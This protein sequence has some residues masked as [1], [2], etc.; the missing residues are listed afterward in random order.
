MLSFFKYAIFKWLCIALLKG[1]FGGQS[2]NILTKIRKELKGYN[3]NDIFPLKE[4]I[5]SF[6]GSDRNFTFDDDFI[7][8]ILKTQ[9]DSPLCYPILTLIY[10]HM[11]FENDK[12]HKDHLHPA[13][14]FSEKRLLEHFGSKENIPS[15]Y[16][17]KEYWNGIVNLQLLNSGLNVSKNDID[18]KIWLKD[19]KVNK[20][21]QLIP[22]GISYDFN[23]FA[24]FYEA[25]KKLLK[26]RLKKMTSYDEKG[27][28]ESHPT[29]FV[30]V[31]YTPRYD[32][33]GW[34]GELHVEYDFSSDELKYSNGFCGSWSLTEEQI[35][36]IKAFLKNEDNLRDFFDDNIAYSTEEVFKT[37]HHRE[38]ILH[39]NW[40]GREKTVSVGNGTDIPFKHPF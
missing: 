1:V 22:D 2:D 17:D 31:D 39:F 19:A 9:K 29:G 10:S 6:R 15:V 18:L 3:S 36:R 20:E 23:D 5:E 27:S 32:S 30:I 38:Y 24:A 21:T 35:K 8:G 13:A 25:R 7:E 11:N 4:L 28:V 14:A 34:K 16:L 26:E 12:Y 37:E 33:W 40:N